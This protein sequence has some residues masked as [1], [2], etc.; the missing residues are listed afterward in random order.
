MVKINL[1][2]NKFILLHRKCVYPYEDMDNWK[3]FDE[4]TIPLFTAN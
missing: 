2:L 3:K 1:W 4:T